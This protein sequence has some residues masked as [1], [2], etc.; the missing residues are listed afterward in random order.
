[1]KV[2]LSHGTLSFPGYFGERAL[3]ALQAHAQVVRNLTETEPRDEALAEAAT[4]CDAIIAYRGSPGTAATFDNAPHLKAF[5]RCAVDISTVDVAAASR[6]GILVTRATPGFVDA[7]VELGIGFMVDLARGVS[8]SVQDYRAGRIPEVRPGLQLSGAT[9]GLVGHGRIA[10][11]LA[12]VARAMGMRV[13]AHDPDGGTHTLAEVLSGPDFVICLALSTPETRHMVNAA[14]FAAMRRGAFFINLSRGELV[15][16]AALEAA[17]DSGHLAGA[18]MDVG[19]FPDQMPNPRLAARPDVI[20]TPHIGG[21]TP[22][23]AEHQAM[24]TVRQVAA[25]AAGRLPEGAVNAAQAT[26]FKPR[27]A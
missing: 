12:E 5:L 8:R 24:D 18:A 26:R 22:A 3:A 20:A 15:D 27:L 21:L 9:L 6:Q 14:A 4:G 7:V 11:R 25:L 19:A 1:M 10:R 2:Y 23:A 17:L 13:L 16:E